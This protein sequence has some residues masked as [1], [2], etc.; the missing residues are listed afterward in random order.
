MRWATTIF[1]KIMII[2]GYVWTSPNTML[3]IA[4]GLL[5][6]LSGGGLQF[7]RGCIEF[8]GGWVTST[9]RR[10]P[11]RGAAAMTIGHTILGVDP[12]VLRRCRDH[13]HVHVR[14]YQRW[15]PFFIPAYLLCSLY[16]WWF[17]R[18]YYLENPFEVEAYHQAE[19]SDD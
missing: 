10:L 18:D 8:Y 3:G 11:P 7:S 19:I 5:G 9:L 14:Q 15:G 2:V 12:G 16:L 17:D 1:Q 4:F 13:E 6:L